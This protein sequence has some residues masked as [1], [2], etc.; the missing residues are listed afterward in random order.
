MTQALLSQMEFGFQ[1]ALPRPPI[2]SNA[3]S[4]SD[5]G[6]KLNWQFKP[7]QKNPVEAQFRFVHWRNIWV[8]AGVGA[9]ALAAAVWLALRRRKAA[10]SETA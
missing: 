1:L 7:G 10:V 2:S 4:T 9:V 8:A 3:T 6:R 5:E